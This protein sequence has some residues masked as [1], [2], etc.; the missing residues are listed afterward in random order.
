MEFKLVEQLS[1]KSNPMEALVTYQKTPPSF[2]E[3]VLKLYINAINM[4]LFR[5]SLK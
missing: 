5:T 3:Q 1:T 2:F 4:I